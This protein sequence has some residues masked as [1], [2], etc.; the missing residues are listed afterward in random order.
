M[1]NWEGRTGLRHAGDVVSCHSEA[2][3]TC[4]GLSG[5]STPAIHGSDV[6]T[7]SSF[8]LWKDYKTNRDT[9]GVHG[10]CGARTIPSERGKKR[11]IVFCSL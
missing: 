7:L 10:S 5:H 2:L 6:K 1:G 8:V 11:E 3:A 9:Y 4:P